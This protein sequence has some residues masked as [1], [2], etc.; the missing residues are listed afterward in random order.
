MLDR[1]VEDLPTERGDGRAPA[2]AARDGA[3]GA[4]GAARLRQALR[5]RALLERRAARRPVARARPARLLPARRS[6]S[7]SAHLLAEHPLRRELICMINANDGRQRARAD[8]RLAARG[9]AGRRRRGGR[10]RV[11]DRARGHRRRRA[12]GGD[13]AARAASTG[14]PQLELMRGVDALVEATSRAGTSRGRPGRGHARDDR[15]PAATGF[16]RL[17]AA[18]PEL[19]DRAN[20]APTHDAT[21]RSWW[22]AACRRRSPAG[23][24][25]ARDWSTRPTWSPSR[26]ATGRDGSRTVARVFFAVGEGLRLDWMERELDAR[27]RRRRGC[28]AGRCRRCART[29]LKARRELALRAFQE[30]PDA[31]RRGGRR[32]VPGV[33]RGAAPPPDVLH[34]RP[35]PRGRPDLAGLRLAVRHLREL[36][37]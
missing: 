5:D 26:S 29:S 4:G 37:G 10:A 17:A 19:R 16:E 3:A 34:P 33:P 31:L 20:G 6:S 12:L 24:R 9:R 11:P 35:R 23:T 18:L 14:R 15:S 32:G 30:N 25:C 22:A 28:S 13:R 21:R 36:A 1:A 27:A 8:V 7:A 2:R